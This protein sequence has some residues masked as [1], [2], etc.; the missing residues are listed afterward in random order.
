MWLLRRYDYACLRYWPHLFA[1]ITWPWTVSVPLR[2]SSGPLLLLSNCCLLTERCCTVVLLRCR[3][4]TRYWLPRH[5]NVERPEP[6]CWLLVFLTLWQVLLLLVVLR[7]RGGWLTLLTITCPSVTM[8][9]PCCCDEL[10]FL[11]APNALGTR[12]PVITDDRWRYAQPDMPRWTLPIYDYWCSVTFVVLLLM[13]T[14]NDIVYRAIT[15]IVTLLYWYWWR[16]CWWAL[17][18]RHPPR[19]C[20][21]VIVLPVTR[22]PWFLID[23]WHCADYATGDTNTALLFTDPDYRWRGIPAV[24]TKFVTAAKLPTLLITRL[25]LVVCYVTSRWYVVSLLTI[26]DALCRMRRWRYYWVA[27]ERCRCVPLFHSVRCCSELV[28]LQVIIDAW[29]LLFVRACCWFCWYPIE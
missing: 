24:M 14:L 25:N 4:W 10:L 13:L 2:C 16:Y 1:D 27:I 28:D 23:R 26:A 20:C 12:W 8:T 22:L 7:C 6:C 9:P 5:F 29:W 11:P 19:T 3:C 21:S 17:L 15:L 18:L